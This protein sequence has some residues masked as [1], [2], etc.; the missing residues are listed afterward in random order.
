MQQLEALASSVTGPAEK[1]RFAY[2]CGPRRPCIQG[3][4]AKG[5]H[6]L[7]GQHRLCLTLSAAS[8]LYHRLAT[9]TYM[10]QIA[11]TEVSRLDACHPL[12]VAPLPLSSAWSCLLTPWHSAFDATL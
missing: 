6:C 11:F 2:W 5:V 10:Q 9:F 8:L 1:A 4:L 3:L 7:P 12:P